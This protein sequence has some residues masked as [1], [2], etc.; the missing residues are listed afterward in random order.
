MLLEEID[1]AALT[2]EDLYST[3]REVDVFNQQV[4]QLYMVK[5][6]FPL[7]ASWRSFQ[8]SLYTFIPQHI[9][10]EGR[11]RLQQKATFFGLV[12][13]SFQDLPKN[14]DAQKQALMQIFSYSTSKEG[15]AKRRLAWRLLQWEFSANGQWVESDRVFKVQS[16]L[17]SRVGLDQAKNVQETVQRLWSELPDLQ[18]NGQ[19]S[20]RRSDVLAPGDRLRTLHDKLHAWQELDAL[21]LRFSVDPGMLK[22]L[23]SLAHFS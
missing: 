20:G 5:G 11:M 10:V 19:Y 9:E 14:P 16:S 18:D 17:L 12:D 7:I 2:L 23:R 4:G 22:T 13:G 8:V 15:L 1:F 3:G 6:V 21:A